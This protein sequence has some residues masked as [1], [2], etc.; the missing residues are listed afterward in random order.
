[1]VGICSFVSGIGLALADDIYIVMPGVPFW[2]ALAFIVS[3]SLSVA[4]TKKPK[5]SLGKV[6]L[7]FNIISAL[8]AGTAM[9]FFCLDI[10]VFRMFYFSQCDS[11]SEEKKDPL[12]LE[13]LGKLIVLNYSIKVLLMLFCLLELCIAVSL[14]VF[15]CKTVCH[16]NFSYQPVILQQISIPGRESMAVPLITATSEAESC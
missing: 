14:S 13:V 11:I 6:T 7:A 1:M 10:A 2:T 3:G 8:A 5:L 12:C 4:F 9:I 15:G 16:N